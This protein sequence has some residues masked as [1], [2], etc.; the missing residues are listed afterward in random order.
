[1]KGP[2][3]EGDFLRE[4]VRVLAQ[5]S[6]EMELEQHVGTIE[7]QVPRKPPGGRP[8]SGP[9]HAGNQHKPGQSAADPIGVEATHETGEWPGSC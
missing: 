8:G 7:L 9:G 2:R 4:G 5:E 3:P 1:M 6:M